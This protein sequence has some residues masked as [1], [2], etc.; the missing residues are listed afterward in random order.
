MPLPTNL[1]GHNIYS[2]NSC[3]GHKFTVSGETHLQILAVEAKNE[4]EPIIGLKDPEYDED[5][6]VY[7][8]KDS[9]KVKNLNLDSPI[10]LVEKNC[11][12]KCQVLVTNLVEN[13]ELANFNIY[14]V[15]F[16]EMP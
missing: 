4:F 11:E 9:D 13:I 7:K 15:G 10:L 6:V 14:S 12:G 3:F 8:W 16:K 1:I 5:F 2:R